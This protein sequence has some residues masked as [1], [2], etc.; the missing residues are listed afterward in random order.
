MVNMSFPTAYAVL[1]AKSWPSPSKAPAS[2]PPW[3]ISRLVTRSKLYVVLL[4]YPACVYSLIIST[5][6]YRSLQWQYEAQVIT[7][8]NDPNVQASWGDDVVTVSDSLGSVWTVKEDA[9]G[10]GYTYVTNTSWPQ[11]PSS[12]PL[13]VSRMA[14]SVLSGV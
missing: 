9:D 6:Y 2:Q 10:N 4:L 7:P 8:L 3:R 5:N 12:F 14:I 11:S 13:V 1:Q